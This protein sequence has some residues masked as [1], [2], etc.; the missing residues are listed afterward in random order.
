VLKQVALSVMVALSI[1][2]VA[3]GQTVGSWYP[4]YSTLYHVRA[5]WYDLRSFNGGSARIGVTFAENP[6]MTFFFYFSPTDTAQLQKAS[7]IYASLLSAQA[8]GQ[9]AYVYVS[10][11]DAVN[12]IFY[13]FI[14]V[15]VGPN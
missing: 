1:M 6:T 14:S 13:D 9:S 7:A 5:C 3:A 15:Q 2:S 10:S 4:A 12:T 8:S 11:V